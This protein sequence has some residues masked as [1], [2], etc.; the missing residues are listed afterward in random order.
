ML[1]AQKV[2]TRD[3]CECGADLRVCR[4]CRHFDP[5]SHN[6]CREVM[7]EWVRTKDRANY[8]DYFSPMTVANASGP[9]APGES[10]SGDAR[11][12]FDQLFKK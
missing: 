10:S 4:N 11:A 2:N 8:C 3:E 9:R 12:R 7:A 6:E 1:T 5:T